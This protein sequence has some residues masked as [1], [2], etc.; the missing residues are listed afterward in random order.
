MN[1][2]SDH[3]Q[4]LFSLESRDVVTKWHQKITGRELNARRAK[5]INSSA[6][7][8]REFFRN[9][10]NSNDSVKPL[11]TFYG[12]ASLSRAVVLLLRR[13][14]GEESLTAGHGLETVGWRPVLGG[15]LTAGLSVLGQLKIKTCSGLF[16]DF[17][18]ETDNHICMHVRSEAVDW[19][20]SYETPPAGEEFSLGDLMSRVPDLHAQHRRSSHEIHYASINEMTCTESGG[21]LAKV[22]AKHFDSFKESYADLGFSL[23]RSA[24]WF[25]L[26]CDYDTFKSHSPQYMHT[27]VNKMFGSIPSLHIVKPFSRESRYSQ[28]AI[29]YMLTYILGMLSRYFPTH[30]IALLSGEKGDEIWPAIHSAQRYVEQSFPE[31]VVEF[32]HDKLDASAVASA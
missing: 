25:D 28:M 32:I 27:Y 12:V 5:E 8:A 2:K 1:Q 14:S 22:A 21:F 31:L 29:T 17:V 13:T 26:T 7:Q 23:S 18:R 16:T 11:L 9:A 19:G 3:W 24:D 15:E 6:R 20:L 30:W 10:E 4:L